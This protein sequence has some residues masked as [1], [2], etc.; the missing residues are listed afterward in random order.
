MRRPRNSTPP[1]TGRLRPDSA[2]ISVDLPAPLA[3][4]TATSS[5]FST[6]KIDIADH[7]E[8]A[9]AGAQPLGGEQSV[10][11]GRQRLLAVARGVQ[12]L[13]QIGLE[14]ERVAGDLGRRSFGD[15]LAGVEHDDVI[16]DGHDELHVVLDQQHPDACGCNLTE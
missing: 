7:I 2:R 16:G 10:T 15:L 6:S 3:P 13:A 8:G 11:R 14:H 12:L 5:P 4:S 1:P 9:V